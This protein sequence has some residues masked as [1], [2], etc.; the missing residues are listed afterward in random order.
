MSTSPRRHLIRVLGLLLV[1]YTL[2]GQPD[3]TI[4]ASAGRA[5][6]HILLNDTTNVPRE[7]A[8]ERLVIGTAVGRRAAAS[9][10][11][12]ALRDSSTVVRYRAL[13]GLF[14]LGPDAEVALPTLTSILQSASDPLFEGAAITIGAI[15]RATPDVLAVL[16]EVGTRAPMTFASVLAK[17]GDTTMSVFLYHAGLAVPSQRPAALAA[18]AAFEKERALPELRSALADSSPM[19]RI[20]GARAIGEIGPAASAAWGDLVPLLSDTTT[21]ESFTSFVRNTSVAA[22]AAWSLSQIR[23][24]APADRQFAMRMRVDTRAAR[25]LRDDG[26]GAYVWGADSVSVVGGPGFFLRLAAHNSFRGPFGP[27]TLSLRRSLGFDLSSPVTGSG[28]KPLGFVRD[29]EAVILIAVTVGRDSTG[30]VKGIANNDLPV[31]DT[32]SVLHRVEFHFRIGGHLHLLQLGDNW[33]GQA[34]APW[35]TGL[36]GRGTT[37]TQIVHPTRDA[38]IVAAPEGSIGRLWDLTDRAHPVDRGLYK[39]SFRTHWMTF[40]QGSPAENPCIGPF[41]VGRVQCGW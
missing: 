38:W 29:N 11:L 23:P 33:E 27:T 21:R 39:F 7:V 3:P 41:P 17:L 15:G 9:E 12:A 19:I 25:S 8:F 35:A 4:D 40:P 10:F 26:L 14:N 5:L 28:S 32:A 37:N 2:M 13:D 36:N 20:V 31:S 22:V 30:R 24:M 16:H 1:P 18:L 6:A 34:E